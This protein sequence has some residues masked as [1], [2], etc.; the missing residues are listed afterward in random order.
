MNNSLLITQTLLL[1]KIERFY[2][3]Y[4]LS[5]LAKGALVSLGL[6]ISLFLLIDFAEYFG[7]FSSTVR[8]VLFYSYLVVLLS[9]LI[10]GIGIPLARL[11]KISKGLSYEDAAIMIGNSLPRVGDKL[12][13]ALQIM[14]MQDIDNDLLRAALEQKAREIKD[15][16]YEKAVNF[17]INKKFIPYAAVPSVILAAILL[18]QPEVITKSA[19]RI[20]RHE[21]PYDKM[22]PFEFHL[23]A[24]RTE[25]VQGSDVVLKLAINGDVIPAD[26]RVVIGPN[27]FQMKKTGPGTFEYR[28]YALSESISLKCEAAGYFSDPM[29]IT[30]R[31]KPQLLH[32]E[33]YARYPSYLNKPDEEWKSAD[34]ISVPEGTI[35]SWM[36]SGKNIDAIKFCVGSNCKELDKN[37]GKYTV[38]KQVDSGFTYRILVSNRWISDTLPPSIVEVIRDEYPSIR[39]EVQNDSDIVAKNHYITGH[40]RDDHGFHSLTAHFTLGDSSWAEPVEFNRQLNESRFFYLV[41]TDRFRLTD[42]EKLHLYFSV[43]DNDALHHFK[44]T[45]SRKITFE[46]PSEKELREAGNEKADDIQKKLDESIDLAKEIDRDLKKLDEDLLKKKEMSWSDKEKLKE[47]VEKRKK[48][49]ENLNEIEEEMKAFREIRNDYKQPSPEILEKQKQLDELFEK[50]FDEETKKM[51]EELEKL[52]DELDKNKLREQLEKM[53]M[54]AEELEEALDRN[55]ELFKQLEFEADM[56]KALSQLDE[57]AQKQEDLSKKTE[58]KSAPPEELKK[59]QDELN[60]AFEDLKKELERLEEK[61]KEL[62]SPMDIDFEKETS[63]EIS[64]KQQSASEKLGQ[65]K[66]K[67]AAQDQKDAAQKMREMETRMS[68]SMEMNTSQQQMEDYNTLREIME[69]LLK[70]SFDE[71]DLLTELG[72]LKPEDPKV[73]KIS[74]RQLAIKESM[75]VVRDSL[76]ALGKRVPQIDPVITKELGNIDYSFNRTIRMLSE[77]QLP[78]AKAEQQKAMTSINNLAVMLDEVLK[79]MQQQM[80]SQNSGNGQCKK[81]GQGKP[82]KPS[83]QQMKSLQKQLNKQ[84]Q[85]LKKQLEKGNAP[86]KKQGGQSDQLNMQLVKAAAKQAMI[87]DEIQRMAKELE[88]QG[89]LKEGQDLKRLAEMMEKTEEDIVNRELTTEMLRRQQEIM[90]RLLKAENAMRERE[91]DNKRKSNEAEQFDVANQKALEEFRKKKEEELEILRLVPVGINEYF[92]GK[93]SEYMMKTTGNGNNTR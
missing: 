26:A 32:L 8:A 83:L 37:S 50:L 23:S 62:E 75:Q 38:S 61:N 85:A 19:E 72:S 25:V 71:E 49:D 12:L 78:Q 31:P 39:I 90:T 82:G 56:E 93:V 14:H 17:S 54:D 4:Y 64:E 2:K 88:K 3:R 66:N 24:D 92:K 21:V 69:N 60:E 70:L 9:A 33:L 68:M 13:N 63:D 20:Y 47:I 77:R 41:N 76:V 59:E 40:I 35:L 86:G 6:V 29:T 16:P 34:H 27:R 36:I 55:L 91:Y 57:L 52:M 30:I 65:K 48:L 58:D 10:Y 84:I 22:A 44:K 87:R 81:P 7:N 42:N 11:L 80:Q 51:F 73:R 43:R 18:F 89:A 28:L 74:E 1:E 53:Q 46:K 15:E 79:Q 5:K 45:D 67:K